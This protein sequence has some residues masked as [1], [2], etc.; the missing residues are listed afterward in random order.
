MNWT[1]GTFEEQRALRGRF[2]IFKKALKDNFVQRMA[3]VYDNELMK[4]SGMNAD[5][6][7]FDSEQD[8]AD[9]LK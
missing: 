2:D 1:D 4:E 7:A 5:Q 9:Y 3:N 6:I 8:R